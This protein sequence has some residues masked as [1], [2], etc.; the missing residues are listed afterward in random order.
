MTI[1]LRLRFNHGRFWL[2]AL[3]V[4]SASSRDCAADDKFPPE[5][6]RFHPSDKNPVFKAAGSGHWDARIRER[7]WILR[8]GDDW[9]LWY[10][11][12]DGSREGLKMLGYATSRDGLAW[13]RHKDNPIYKEH[14]VEDMMVV[15]HNGTF[16]MF[17][18][19]RDDVAQLL[20]S[21]DGVRWKREGS[22]DVRRTGGQP[23]D[24]GP[25]GTPT[26]W[27]EDGVWHLFY[28][29]GDKAVWL[30][31]S[32]DLKTWTNVSDDPVLRPGP[33]DYDKRMIALNQIV[34]HGGRYY[35]YYHG[36]G[37]E[38]KPSRW[39]TNIATSTDLVRWE[40]YA[41]NPLLPVEANKSSGILIHDGKKFRLYTMH[42][43]V[44]V[45]SSE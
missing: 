10:T 6:V 15:R 20:T 22:L 18:E 21:K 28:E 9:H 41:G 31:K 39:T 40:K 30:A 44:Q 34:K 7:G 16:Y 42:D 35:A 3:V 25:Y 36:T 45:H 14:W 19:G 4:A 8:D 33:G 37:E 5:L 38:T 29:R 32:R 2:L 1:S 11:G 12:Y 23:I 17:A 13:T 27:L 26:A 24:A 43:E